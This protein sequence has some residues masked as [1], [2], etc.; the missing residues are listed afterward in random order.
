MTSEVSHAVTGTDELLQGVLSSIRDAVCVLSCDG[1]ILSSND[2][3]AELGL[4][5]SSDVPL[6][7]LCN[8]LVGDSSGATRAGA[9][10][11]CSKAPK[12]STPM[13]SRDRR[14]RT[15]AGFESRSLRFAAETGP[16]SWCSP[17]SPSTRRPKRHCSRM[18]RVSTWRVPRTTAAWVW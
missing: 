13:S 11:P 6:D 2:A 12:T 14:R 18:A 4:D 3:W 5:V 16:P 15:R 17:I 10:R 8:T 7:I 1:R 9:S